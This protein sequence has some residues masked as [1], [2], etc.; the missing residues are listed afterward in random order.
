M[1]II[2]LAADPDGAGRALA[3][4]ERRRFASMDWLAERF[5]EQGLL[6]P[7]VTPEHAAH[8]VRLLA[9]FDAYDLLAAGRGLP[10]PAAAEILIDVAERALFA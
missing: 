6:R 8:V 1:T 10:P 5:A 3:A 9:S 4:S 2:D 7:D